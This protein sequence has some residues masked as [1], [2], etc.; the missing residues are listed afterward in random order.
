MKCHQKI[1]HNRARTAT[2]LSQRLED[3]VTDTGDCPQVS[4]G[5]LSTRGKDSQTPTRW[6]E[7]K[8]VKRVLPF[9]SQSCQTATKLSQKLEDSVTD[10]GKGPRCW[11]KTFSRRE[12]AASHRRDGGERKRV[13]PFSSQ[14]YRDCHQTFPNAGRQCNIRFQKVHR[15]CKK[16]KKHTTKNKKTPS[17]RGERATRRRRGTPEE[18]AAA[19]QNNNN[20]HTKSYR[21]FDR[22]ES[23]SCLPKKKCSVLQLPEKS[24]V[25]RLPFSVAAA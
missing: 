8:R 17:I 6:R 10:T 20:T 23:S 19:N 25:Q 13:L 15:C 12:K 16:K 7:R 18:T 14:L 11:K 22:C 3:S 4:E 2:K 21:T 5:T 1:G 9:S 24:S